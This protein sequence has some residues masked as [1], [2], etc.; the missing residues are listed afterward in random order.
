MKHLAIVGPPTKAVLAEVKKIKTLES[1]T[2]LEFN[3]N[4]IEL[5]RA[6]LEKVLPNVKV[7]ARDKSEFQEVIDDDFLDHKEKNRAQIRMR[8]LKE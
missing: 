6:G 8:Y 4:K 1:F 2:L 3:S 5:L 7:D